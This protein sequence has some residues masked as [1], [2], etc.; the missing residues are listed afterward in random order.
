MTGHGHFHWTEFVTRDPE[1]FKTFYARTVGW[2]YEATTQPDGE[3]YW[4]A[5]ANGEPV[6]GNLSHQPTRPGGHSRWL[7][8][9]YRRR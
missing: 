6:G 5:L 9:V 7:D 2:T 4:V 8:A 1:G 3:C